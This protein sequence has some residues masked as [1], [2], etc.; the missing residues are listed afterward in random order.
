MV[1]RDMKENFI[2]LINFITKCVQI[3]MINV[4]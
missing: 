3:D 4:G 1:Q 2:I